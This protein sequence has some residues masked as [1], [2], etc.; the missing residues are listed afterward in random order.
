MPVEAVPSH[1]PNG[2]KIAYVDLGVKC[3][4]VADVDGRYS[5]T[6]GIHC[7]GL[8]VLDTRDSK[9]SRNPE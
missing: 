1:Q 8:V 4:I 3:P 6:G 5:D 9:I 7:C 2:D